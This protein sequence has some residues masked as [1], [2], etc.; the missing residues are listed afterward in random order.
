MAV[1]AA[2]V[3]IVAPCPAEARALGARCGRVR[4]PLDRARPDGPALRIWFERYPRSQQ[5]ARPA[6][7]TVLSLEGGPGAGASGSRAS[8]VRLWRPLARRRDLLLVDLRGTGR[9]GALACPALARSTVGYGARAGRCAR[10]LGPR[11]DLYGT[12]TAVRDLA[13]VLDALGV[14][15]GSVDL[16]GDSYGTYAAQAFA[17]RYPERLR[18]LVL[19]GAYPLPGTD[20]LWLDLLGAVRRGLVASCAGS[21]ATCPPGDPIARLGAVAR[22]LRAR[23][24]VGTAPDGDGTPT[25]VRLD[26]A[27]LAQ[28]AAYGYAHYAVWRDLPAA[29]GSARRGDPGPLL[30]LAAESVTVDAGE[31]SPPDWSDALYLAVTCRDYPQAWDVAAPVAERRRQY[32]AAIA[33]RP[34]AAFRPFSRAAWTA[35]D[36]EGIDACLR[37]PAPAGGEPPEPPGA[38]YPDVP[39]LVLNGELDTITTSA[40]AREVARRFPRATFVE[41]RGS[42]HVTALGDRDRCAS[43]LYA[44]FVRARAA[45]DVGCAGRVAPQRLVPAF[46]RTLAAVRG[47]TAAAGDRSLLADR[48]L[49]EVALRTAADVLARWW[50]NYDGDGVGLRGGTW[51]Y[52]GDRRTTFRLEAVEWLSGAPVTGSVV[53]DQRRGTAVARLRVTGP[54]GRRVRLVAGWSTVRAGAVAR[55]AGRSAAGPL[56]ARLL[57]P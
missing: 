54:G 44:R 56:V 14:P 9:S 27:A 13:D 18:T 30:R 12:G 7:G 17:L 49:A 4:V 2:P 32:A 38:T 10:E 6:T 23:A 36:Y 43:A 39:T 21:R 57:A 37:W 41:V 16:Y 47:A 55:I 1:V 45:G 19:D 50:V 5:R 52:A 29:L 31:A 40:Q 15:A 53:W 3:A 24:M 48:R 35:Q 34:L 22:A 26:E 28:T 42:I 46:P 11:R 51:S 8:R 33:A 20:P 25:R